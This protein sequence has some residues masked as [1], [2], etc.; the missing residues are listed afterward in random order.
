MIYVVFLVG[1]IDHSGG[2]ESVVCGNKAEAKKIAAAFT[3]DQKRI[4]G[5]DHHTSTDILQFK[6]P[7]SKEDWLNF[8]TNMKSWHGNAL[9]R[10]YQRTI[11]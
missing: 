1:H 9:S 2:A 3:K 7:K 8:I 10:K 6:T 4:Y 5:K 11:K